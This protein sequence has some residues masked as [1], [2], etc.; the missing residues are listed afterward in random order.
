MALRQAPETEMAF[1]IE[2]V[3]NGGIPPGLSVS[4]AQ[5]SFSPENWQAAQTVT[6]T[7]PDRLATGATEVTTSLRILPAADMLDSPLL[8]RIGITSW[9]ALW[10]FVAFA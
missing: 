10:M 2:H 5:L 3:A 6:V 4:P 7:A 8:H 9:S 1:S